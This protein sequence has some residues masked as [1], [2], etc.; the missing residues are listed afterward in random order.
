MGN[1]AVLWRGWEE[2]CGRRERVV[3]SLCQRNVCLLDVLWWGGKSQFAG[4]LTCQTAGMADLLSGY[5]S[6]NIM[7]GDHIWMM[8]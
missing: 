8:K 5:S 1:L 7:K 3:C 6:E 4:R 2:A